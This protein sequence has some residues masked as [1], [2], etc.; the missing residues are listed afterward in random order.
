MVSDGVEPDQLHRFAHDRG[1]AELPVEVHYVLEL[2]EDRRII[3]GEWTWRSHASHPDLLWIGM[4][5]RSENEAPDDTSDPQGGIS[6]DNP[7]VSYEH[8]L[9]LLR[10]ANDPATCQPSDLGDP[11]ENLCAGLCG[12]WVDTADA[13]CSCAPCCHWTNNCCDADGGEQASRIYVDQVCDQ[14]CWLGDP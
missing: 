3:D 2:D 12:G 13:S 10:C 6:K 8:A 5:H 1:L 7:Y 14:T 11:A 4:S 9:A